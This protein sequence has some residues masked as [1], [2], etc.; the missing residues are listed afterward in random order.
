MIM[1]TVEIGELRV[2]ND[3]PFTLIAG[4][5]QIESAEH[6]GEVA[7]ALAAMTRELGI[8]LIFKSSY[9]KANRTSL[10]AGRGVGMAQGLQILA[11]IRAKFG[12]PVLTDV[13]DA[14]QCAPAAEA[15][16]VL[17][18]PAFLCRQTDLLLAAGHTGRAIN[19]KKGQF[20]APWDMR[21]VAAKIASTGN[22]RILLT[23]RGASFGYNTLVS[24][25]RALPIMAQTGY[26]VVFDA[27]HSV[28]QPGGQ[29]TASGGQREF[30]PILARAALAVGCAAVFIEC[31]PDPDHAPSDG[32][33]MIRLAE[34]PALLARLQQFDRLAKS[35]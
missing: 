18:I 5:C 14:A 24:D 11:D 35:A 28:Q 26:P 29:G 4:P 8:G 13:H 20:L 22:E 27:T 6:A 23:E 25:L 32:P 31:H 17:Q 10:T 15:V 9:D 16:D 3:L 1:K 30:A 2:G 21:N 7:G 19:V 34:M 12:I 33:N